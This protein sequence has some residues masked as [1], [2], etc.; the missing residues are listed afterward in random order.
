MKILKLFTGKDG[1]THFMDT[2][3]EL[4]DGGPIGKLSE[5]IS[6]TGVIFRETPA[7]YDYDYHN[8]PARQFIVMLDA[9]LEIT[10]ASGEKRVVKAG[11]VILVEDT[12]GHG[13]ISKALKNKPR[14]SIFIILD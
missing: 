6:A 13:H 9:G 7:D 2:E 8:A 4:K 1:E 11:E 3:I 10:V 5:L 12:K 14:K